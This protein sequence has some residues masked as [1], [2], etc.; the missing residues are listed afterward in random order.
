MTIW[1]VTLSHLFQLLEDEKTEK[2]KRQKQTA[3]Q[4][5]SVIWITIHLLTVHLLT[6]TQSEKNITAAMLNCEWFKLDW[7][8][9]LLKGPK[10]KATE[11]STTTPSP[12]KEP[13]PAPSKAASSSANDLL[14]LGSLSL[15]KSHLTFSNVHVLY[16][17]C[18]AVYCGINIV[19]GGSMFVGSVGH[20]FPQIYIFVNN[21]KRYWLF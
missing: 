15:L 9:C 8:Y 19:D 21:V 6:L 13:T 10:S 14:G 4:L 12:K 18:M 11:S 5:S 1:I 20:P 16:T 3:V 7:I 2:K 17:T